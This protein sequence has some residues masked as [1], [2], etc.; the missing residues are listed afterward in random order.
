MKQKFAIPRAD[1]V[2]FQLVSMTANSTQIEV[3]DT[4]Y[5]ALLPENFSY[6]LQ[7]RDSITKTHSTT[8]INQVDLAPE[9]VRISGI[10][11]QERRLMAGTYMDGWSRLK[12][13]EETIVRQS[14]Q[15]D[16][17]T[18]YSINYYDYL[19]QRF[20]TINISDWSIDGNAASNTRM[21]KYSL[22]F[23]ITGD[24][25]LVKEQDNML[26]ALQ[27]VYSPVDGIYKKLI[28][29][30]ESLIADSPMISEG[31]EILQITM[32]AA[33]ALVDVACVISSA[34]SAISGIVPTVRSAYTQGVA[35]PAMKVIKAI[36]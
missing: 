4:I 31:L 2:V 9:R 11:G 13:F 29:E 15:N 7:S 8:F 23:V 36:F 5:L 22:N 17:G 25:V 26:T 16:N 6:G 10:F 27:Y 34:Y 19:F 3:I 12:Q 33:S 24:L 28:D 20:G 30:A 21:I 32:E 1:Y 18:Y 35:Q 14:K